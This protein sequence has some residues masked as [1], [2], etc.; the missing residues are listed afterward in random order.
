M[1][2]DPVGWNG[3]TT[4]VG[5]CLLSVISAGRYVFSFRIFGDLENY[6]FLESLGPTESEKQCLHFF[7]AP[8]GSHLGFSKWPP[9]FTEIWQ[10]LSF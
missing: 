2:T 10:Y 3:L 9:F 1:A 8:Y 5:L 7:Q 4:D 6:T